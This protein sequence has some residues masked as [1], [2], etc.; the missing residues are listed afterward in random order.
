MTENSGKAG[1][2]AEEVALTRDGGKEK[3]T[4]QLSITFKACK[5]TPTGLDT[6]RWRSGKMNGAIGDMGFELVETDRRQLTLVVR[7]D[8]TGHY[9]FAF[10]F[11][12]L[13][14]PIRLA[15]VAR[16]RTLTLVPEVTCEGMVKH[17]PL[18]IA[19]DDPISST[20][21]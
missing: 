2:A 1:W 13:Q 3:H 10:A 19:S 15:Y 4:G 20:C 6:L 12:A 5:G 11:V 18:G 14:W 7:L 16:D 17:D 8:G 9:V 21:R